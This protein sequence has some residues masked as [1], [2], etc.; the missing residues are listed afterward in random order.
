MKKKNC[1]N[2]KFTIS[3]II[4]TSNL[5][6]SFLFVCL[7]LFWLCGVFFY[8]V[9]E[10]LTT[11]TNRER[12]KKNN[13]G[14]SLIWLFFSQSVYHRLFSLSFYSLF[15]LDCLS[16]SVVIVVFFFWES[17]F[18]LSNRCYFRSKFKWHFVVERER[19]RRERKKCKFMFVNVNNRKYK[20]KL[21]RRR[22]QQR[23]LLSSLS[24]FFP[25]KKKRAK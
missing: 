12:E 10:I 21:R 4:R 17:S 18:I 6:R 5:K 11:S 9:F 16:L 20:R 22:R 25:C 8:Y 3:K 15:S 1:V 23:V 13:K 7:L 2:I 19:E 24:D 14:T